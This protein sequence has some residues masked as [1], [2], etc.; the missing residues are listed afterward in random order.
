MNNKDLI[1]QYINTGMGIPKEQY[2][3][4]SESEKK[5]YLRKMLIRVKQDANY[6]KYYY[7][8]LPEDV[9]LVAVTQNYKAIKD[10]VNPSEATQIAAVTKN[11]YIINDILNKG[12]T[13]S[14]AVQ[15]AAVTKDSDA[16]LYILR[17]GITPSEAVQIAAVSKKGHLIAFI[18]EKGITPSERV[19]LAAKQNMLGL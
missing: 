11:G 19:K 4:L 3:M 6:I 16:I 18:I 17:K 14:E 9:Q 8:E 7:D 1:N 10:I 2:D 13:P 5:T 15:L 12:I